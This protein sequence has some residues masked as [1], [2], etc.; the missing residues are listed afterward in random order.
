MRGWIW[1]VVGALT[2]GCDS[3]PLDAD[4]S[5]LETGDTTGEPVPRECIAPEGLGSPASI[6]EVVELINAL[7]KPTSLPCFLESLDRPLGLAAT[8]SRSSAQ[9]STGAENPRLFISRAPLIMSVLPE[10]PGSNKLEFAVDIGD[11]LSIKGELEF[12]IEDAIPFTEPYAQVRRQT[13]TICG[14]CHIRE[15]HIETVDEVAIFA[16]EALQHPPETDISPSYV[17]ALEGVCDPA[18]TPDR[19]SMLT[20]VFGHGE[21]FAEPLPSNI[22]I[23]RLVE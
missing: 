10:G 9:P 6:E 19:C 22:K 16:S 18:S 5:G 12:P 3:E 15:Q 21:T 17:G 4:E 7:P 23:C 11:G 20:A 14:A 2:L 1:L 8:D 13:G